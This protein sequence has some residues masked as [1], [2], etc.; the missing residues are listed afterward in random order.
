MQARR[1]TIMTKANKP[2]SRKSGANSPKAV[3]AKTPGEQ[4]APM[5]GDETAASK[6]RQAGKSDKSRIGGTAVPGAKS[7]RPREI[8][9]ASPTQQQAESYSREM[10]R[11][12]Q[13]MGTGPYGEDP[14]V[15]A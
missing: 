7:T 6:S 11:R 12:M 4:Q 13:H 5:K 8:N 15:A 10:R 1:D 9:T 14:A 3:E 2:E